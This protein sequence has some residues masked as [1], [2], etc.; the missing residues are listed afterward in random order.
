MDQEEVVTFTS[1]TGA[2]GDVTPG[3]DS[4]NESE[5]MDAML[6]QELTALQKDFDRASTFMTSV[7]ANLGSEKLLYFYARF[8]QATVGKC[9]ICR[10]GMFNFQGKQ[11][12]DAW[13]AL[14]DMSKEQAMMEYI[15]A[16]DEVDPDWNSKVKGHKSVSKGLGVGVSTMLAEEEAELSDQEKSIF[17]W[18]K[19]GAEEQVRLLLSRED[20]SINQV[21]EDG[22]TLL[23]WA[24]DRGHLE[25]VTLL[26]ERKVNVNAPDPD[27]QTPLHYACTCEHL[28]IIEALVKHGGSVNTK[29]A[30]GNV[31]ADNTYR[32]DIHQLLATN[33]DVT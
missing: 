33:Y 23:H 12:W 15:E 22:L 16:M 3:D 17:D 8:K 25:V 26:L 4:D 21:D 9:N 20:S 30:D 6:E 1:N 10:P 14:K 2:S 32:K 31:P 11:K 27:G 5:M 7:A 13:N 18:C 28:P 24:C 29:D 19:E